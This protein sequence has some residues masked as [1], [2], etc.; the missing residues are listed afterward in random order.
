MPSTK[1][2]KPR[3]FRKVLAL[4]PRGNPLWATMATTEEEARERFER[5]NPDPTGE[6]MGETYVKAEINLTK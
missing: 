5:F 4:D 1:V 3:R 6:G 2:N